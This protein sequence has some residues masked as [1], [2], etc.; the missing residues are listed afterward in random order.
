[1]KLSELGESKVIEVLTEMVVA[2]RS[3]PDNATPPGFQ[4]Q[5]DVGDDTAAWNPGTGTEL[6]TTDTIVEGVH[7]TLETASWH[8]L[9]W[10]IMA[11]NVSDIAAMGGHSLYALV[12]LGLPSETEVDDL[13]SLYQGM[14]ELGNRY[15]VRVVGGDV[16]RSRV[17]F[18]T[19]ALTGV[20][21]SEPMLRSNAR[22]NDRIAVTGFLGS[23]AGGLKVIQDGL[24]NELAES[25]KAAHFRPDPCVSEGIFLAGHGVKAA[26]D[27][28]DG[29]LEDLSKLCRAS[30]V[31][32]KIDAAKIPVLPALK[33]LFPNEYLD[34]ALG[35]GEDYQLL[36]TAPSKLMD[37]MIRTLP[38][39]A[40]VIGDVV[41]GDVGNVEAID[42]RTGRALEPA[43]GGW[44][45][46][47]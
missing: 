41:E 20:T 8:D 32:A 38:S 28:S 42:S 6:F 3:G 26:M 4:L 12:T 27:I 7:F 13:K 14:L 1:M 31:A 40:A 21:D 17:V 34:L 44:D 35:G 15:G 11:A 9:G 22:V 30:R 46:F 18:I 2:S 47:R 29:L 36:F 45:H 19:I 37:E 5:V 10:K 16:V 43:H 33:E 24:A 39:P 23:A 25:L